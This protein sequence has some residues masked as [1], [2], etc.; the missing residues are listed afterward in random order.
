MTTGSW[1][2]GSQVGM[3]FYADKTWNGAD[4]PPGWRRANPG[5]QPPPHAYSMTCSRQTMSKSQ[6]YWSVNPTVW[7]G[8]VYCYTS[9]STL[10]PGFTLPANLDLTAL[11][12]LSE[13]IR[14]H[15]FNLAVA[16]AE[17]PE[18]IDM[19][20]NTS[21][22]V[23]RAARATVRGDWGSVVRNL[24]R[25]LGQTKQ[26]QKNW[27]K[28]LS[29]GDLSAAWLALR[30]G[31]EPLVNDAFE[32]AKA[33][34]RMTSFART[35]TFRAYANGMSGS[36]EYLTISNG[37]LKIEDKHRVSYIVTLGEV[38]S[39]A[40]SLGLMDPA[41]VL[42]EKLPYSFVADW[43]IPIGNYLSEASFFNG[44]NTS[45]VKSVFSRRTIGISKR[46]TYT[47]AA[48]YPGVPKGG[49]YASTGVRFT[50]SIGSAID[51][52]SPSLKAWAKAFSLGHLQ[53]AAALISQQIALTSGAIA[54]HRH[55]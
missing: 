5:K 2:V 41:S 28:A 22:A 43:F 30:Y 25:S 10:V 33:V 52:P 27:D 35:L 6:I 29:R 20:R 13:K 3:D 23:L 38:P 53:N 36:Y 45:Y 47:G 51:V 7:L 49:N 19:L 9:S 15:S 46:A 4:L 55:K 24:S 31:W 48:G 34:E 12:K 54:A 8:D 17:L 1:T 40:R 44:L 16:A 42:W 50:R 32:A 11:G 37:V 18:A 39:T 14:G 26:A 21:T